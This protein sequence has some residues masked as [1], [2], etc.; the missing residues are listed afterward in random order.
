MTIL[1]CLIFKQKTVT[2]GT[3]TYLS[4]VTSVGKNNEQQENGQFK[5]MQRVMKT[6]VIAQVGLLAKSAIAN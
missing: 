4:A 6:Y 2:N 1:N 5:M 3:R